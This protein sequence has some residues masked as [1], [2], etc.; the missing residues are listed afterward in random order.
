MPR[1]LEYVVP[2]S[3]NVPRST[4]TT[5]ARV[6]FPA[7][8][9]VPLPFI[10]GTDDHLTPLAMVRRNARAYSQAG[11]VVDFQAFERRSH[12]ICNQDGWEDVAGL[13]AGLDR[14]PLNQDDS[15]QHD[16]A[17]VAEIGPVLAVRH[18]QRLGCRSTGHSALR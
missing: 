1:S 7:P 17:V 5:Q 4:L 9:T 16:R 14:S 12:F 6:R 3:R 8:A 11:G 2:E 13:R 15:G 18:P 10:G